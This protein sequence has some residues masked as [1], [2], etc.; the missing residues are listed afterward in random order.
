METEKNKLTDTRN[1]EQNI[2]DDEYKRLER[3]LK[4]QIEGLKRENDV[5]RDNNEKAKIREAELG[6]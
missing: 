4:D 3:V 5:L 6:V 1:K 2:R